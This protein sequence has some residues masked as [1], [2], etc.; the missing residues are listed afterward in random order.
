MST[1]QRSEKLP[2]RR[3]NPNNRTLSPLDDPCPQFE[4]I[5][6]AAQEPQFPKDLTTK[7]LAAGLTTLIAPTVSNRCWFLLPA[8]IG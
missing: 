2:R 1:G 5:K 4:T 8:R 6:S 3:Q 7:V